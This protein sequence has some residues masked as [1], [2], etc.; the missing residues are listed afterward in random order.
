MKKLLALA[1][2]LCMLAAALP[3]PAESAPAGSGLADL[4][5]G[6]LEGGESEDGE[7]GVL[8]RLIRI[9]TA[10]KEKF[11]GGGEKIQEILSGLLDRAK[12]LLGSLQEGE[13]PGAVLSGLGKKLMDQLKD[14][15]IDVRGMLNG[16]LGAGEEDSSLSAEEQKELD[17]LYDEMNGQALAENGEG[18]ANR[19]A[20]ESAEEFYGTWTCVRFTVG[21]EEYDMSEDGWEMVLGENTFYYIEDGE[22]SADNGKLPEVKEMRLENGVLKV[23]IN[24]LWSV[25]VLTEDG[26]LADVGS[27]M[28]VYYVRAEQ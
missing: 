8:S 22:I 20:A 19:K 2:T 4:L 14:S 16:L 28:V 25:F 26:G 13:G 17:R 11:P 7:E 21:G 24:S 10:L 15:G 9:I 3:A 12:D 1:L 27:T 18:V 5:S 23:L 6:L